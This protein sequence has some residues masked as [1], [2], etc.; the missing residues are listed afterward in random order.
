MS[1]LV[2]LLDVPREG[3]QTARRLIR[4]TAG[5]EA[6]RRR[7]IRAVRQLISPATHTKQHQ[8]VAQ[9]D[10]CSSKKM[11]TTAAVATAA[12]AAVATAAGAA[13]S[14]TDQ[15]VHNVSQREPNSLRREKGSRL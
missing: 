4:Q 10:S 7:D 5:F 11:S 2:C 9:L 12:A 6:I 15:Y 8:D 1:V 3:R 13:I 14:D